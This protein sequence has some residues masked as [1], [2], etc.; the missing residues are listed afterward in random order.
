MSKDKPQLRAY[1]AELDPN[2]K[3]TSLFLGCR[4]QGGYSDRELVLK[5]NGNAVPFCPR[6]EY[7]L[8]KNEDGTFT[9]NSCGSL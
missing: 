9:C 2:N 4:S 5:V 1:K 6:C 8:S 7:E 3:Q